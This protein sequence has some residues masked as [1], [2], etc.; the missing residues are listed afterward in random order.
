MRMLK[1]VVIAMFAMLLLAQGVWA[2]MTTT[3]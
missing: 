1:L 2:E 3:K